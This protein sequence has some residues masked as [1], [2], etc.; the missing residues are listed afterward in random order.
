MQRYQ[1]HAEMSEPHGLPLPRVNLIPWWECHS[2]ANEY[3]C[4]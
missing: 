4:K 3:T 2:V 1:K